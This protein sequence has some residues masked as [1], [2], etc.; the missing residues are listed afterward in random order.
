MPNEDKVDRATI[1]FYFR[2]LPKFDKKALTLSEWIAKVESRFDMC[3]IREDREKRNTCSVYIGETGE[4]ILASL[5]DDATW[6]EAKAA[7]T[8]RL[9]EGNEGEEAWEQLKG[10][11][12]GDLDLVDLGARVEKLVKKVFPGQVDTQ[13][14]HA[15]EAFVRCLDPGLARKVQEQGHARLQEV[16]TT[17]RRLEKLERQYPTPGLDSFAA[18]L[19]DELSQMKKELADTNSALTALRSAKAEPAIRMAQ[20][21]PPPSPGAAA[22][23]A[24]APPGPTAAYIPEGYYPAPR[25]QRNG[26]GRGGRRNPPPPRGRGK[27]FLCDEE[28]HFVAQ[29]PIKLELQRAHRR[30][31]ASPGAAADP[32][33]LDAQSR[34]SASLN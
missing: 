19:K 8:Q 14:K 25:F 12:R 32:T 4:D 23:Y 18:V 27:C 24:P 7:L 22:V 29:C 30:Q 11:T 10:L 17:A 5:A 15:V 34:P 31:T 21:P 16:I 13:E 26:G 9:G 28:G 1:E 6:A 3:K 20:A 2:S 33:V